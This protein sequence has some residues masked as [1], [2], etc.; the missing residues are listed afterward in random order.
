[1]GGEKEEIR[2]EGINKSSSI[3]ILSKFRDGNMAQVK[4]LELKSTN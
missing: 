4:E 3:L 1:M 2:K